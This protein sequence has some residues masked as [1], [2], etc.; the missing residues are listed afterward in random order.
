MKKLLLTLTSGLFL[1]GAMAQMPS[2]WRWQT[3]PST[4]AQLLN[5]KHAGGTNWYAAGLGATILKSA[6]DG[7]TWTLLQAPSGTNV[8]FNIEHS[9]FLS[10]GNLFVSNGGVVYKSTDAGATWNDVNATF[11]GGAYLQFADNNKGWKFGLAELSKTTDGGAT[12][13]VVSLPNSAS[14]DRP[15]N[16]KMFSSTSGYA[17]MNLGKL[18]M[19]TD[20]TAWTQKL[21]PTRMWGNEKAFFK[22]GS[23]GIMFRDNWTDTV[24]VTTNAAQNW[25][26]RI[27]LQS[28][29]TRTCAAYAGSNLLVSLFDYNVQKDRVKIARST[30][31]GANWTYISLPDRVGMIQDIEM[32]DDLVGLAIG[33]NGCMIKT[34]N[35]GLTWTLL[36]HYGTYTGEDVVYSGNNAVMV[37]QNGAFYSRDGGKTFKPS[38]VSPTDPG[39]GTDQFN[40]TSFLSPSKAVAMGY[41]GYAYF[42]N[43]TGATFTQGA[44]TWFVGTFYDVAYH[45]TSNTI[46][47]VGRAADGAKNY[48]VTT[49]GGSNWTARQMPGAF[50]IRRIVFL[51]DQLA[52]ATGSDSLNQFKA[53]AWY[54]TDGG[55]T[56]KRSTVAGIET[57]NSSAYDVNMIDANN[58]WLVGS[59]IWKTTDG[60]KNWA[61]VTPGITVGNMRGV[62]FKNAQNGFVSGTLGYMIETTDGGNTW[63]QLNPRTRGTLKRFRMKGTT[64]TLLADGGGILSNNGDTGTTGIRVVEP[65]AK[66]VWT[67]YPNPVE[68]KVLHIVSSTNSGEIQPQSIELYQIDGSLVKRFEDLSAYMTLDLKDMTRGLYLLRIEHAKGIEVKRILIP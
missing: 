10:T 58:G 43:D 15:V 23:N 39:V 24:F 25:T 22:D 26:Y 32:K 17:F 27:L 38:L 56:W 64:L 51:N 35:G 16:F 5:I 30:D 33:D 62:Y 13:N 65:V 9:D 68:G 61:V 57:G 28:K 53:A 8:T 42:S 40:A 59:K 34:T 44:Y 19:T 47:A 6:N 50:D 45:A 55:T 7:A 4:S 54:S 52:F 48:T 1:H 21:V 14:E 67:A 11:N 37:G 2:G 20:G 36:N 66:N 29:G 46:F 18:Y 63:T 12:W 31:G 60:G 3:E 49:N 41:G